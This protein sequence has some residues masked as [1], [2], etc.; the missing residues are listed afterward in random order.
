MYDDW[1]ANFA[2][3]AATLAAVAIC[4]LVHYEGLLVLLRGM[5][6]LH[7]R[8]RRIRVLYS[9]LAVVFLHVIEIWVFGLTLWLLLQWPA[10]G[11][12]SGQASMHFF[13]AIYLSAVTYSTVGYGDIAP[14]GAI[15]LLAGTEALVGL[16]LITWS[17]S[18]TY[19]EMQRDW[20]RK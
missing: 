12:V 5:P 14:V 8:H 10:A 6:A 20:P 9:I 3:A 2:V 13:D 18:F 11:H 19:L 7:R 16:V 4:V 1:L 15:R 17:A